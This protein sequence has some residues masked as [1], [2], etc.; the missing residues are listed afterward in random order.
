MEALTA[1]LSRAISQLLR[2]PLFP[3][4]CRRC[5]RPLAPCAGRLGR[6]VHLLRGHGLRHTLNSLT[7]GIA[8]V[9]HAKSVIKIRMYM[10]LKH[11]STVQNLLADWLLLC[12]VFSGALPAVLQQGT[13]PNILQNMSTK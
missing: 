7:A 10:L 2:P 13:S 4:C 3:V 6:L 1:P 5:I 11:V 12:G 9:Q 8:A